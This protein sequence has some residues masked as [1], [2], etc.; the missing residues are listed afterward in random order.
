MVGVSVGPVIGSLY[1]ALS[2]Q[3]FDFFTVVIG[4]PCLL[5]GVAAAALGHGQRSW[6]ECLLARFIK[7]LPAG[8]VL[9]VVYDL[10]LRALCFPAHHAFRRA[11]REEQPYDRTLSRDDVVRGHRRHGDCR[12]LPS[13][14]SLE[15]NFNRRKWPEKKPFGVTL[16]WVIMVACLILLGYPLGK[17]A[18]AEFHWRAMMSACVDAGRSR[19]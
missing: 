3:S 12:A 19:L 5:S 16:R 1:N 11:L 4:L 2:G 17:R 18:L 10:I 6:L 15:A 7:G 13:A 14:F 9:G 8:L